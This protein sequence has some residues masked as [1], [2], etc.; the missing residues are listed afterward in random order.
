MAYDIKNNN[1]SL[2]KIVCQ[3]IFGSPG[4]LVLKRTELDCPEGCG[5]VTQTKIVT[6]KREY[7]DIVQELFDPLSTKQGAGMWKNLLMCL[8]SNSSW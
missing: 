2:K 5:R 6:C 1:L 4:A 8:K 7:F 3:L